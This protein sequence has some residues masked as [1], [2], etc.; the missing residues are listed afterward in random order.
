MMAINRHSEQYVHMP[1]TADECYQ[2]CAEFRAVASFPFTI[3]AID[4]TH[5]KIQ[6]PGGLEAERFRN[7][8]GSFGLNVQTISD[9]S[10]RVR[11][12]VSR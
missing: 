10:L 4:C 11:N 5:V 1:R 2:L 9:R 3:G 6:S 7:R 12:L 8:K